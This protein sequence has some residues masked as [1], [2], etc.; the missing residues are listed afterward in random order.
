LVSNAKIEIM[1]TRPVSIDPEIMSGAAVFSGTRVPVRVFID[2][3]EGGQSV[4]EFLEGFPS[5]SRVQ[6]I[7]FLELVSENAIQLT[8]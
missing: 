6:V 1:F 4:E 2:Y 3:L 5:V 8:R 7:D